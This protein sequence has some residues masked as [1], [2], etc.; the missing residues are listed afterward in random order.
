MPSSS[1]DAARDTSPFEARAGVRADGPLTVDLSEPPA[2]GF[3]GCL[4]VAGGDLLLLDR[5]V[6]IGIPYV[7][8]RRRRHGCATAEMTAF[9]F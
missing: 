6:A 3:C 9:V 2:A 5:F 8:Q 1:A 4:E 7:F